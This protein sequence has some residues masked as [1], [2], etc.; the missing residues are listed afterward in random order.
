MSEHLCEQCGA[1]NAADA[2]F[3][4]K[5]D[6]YLGWDTGGGSLGG[7]PLKSSAPVV[8][9]THSQKFLAIPLAPERSPRPDAP[10]ATGRTSPTRSAMAPKVI[11]ESPEV[12]LD[13]AEGG[14]VD[15]RIH[16][17]SSIVDGYTVEAPNGPP[18]LTI[19]QPEIRLLT[20]QEEVFTV[21]LGMRPEYAVYVQRLRLRVQ[22]CS[23]EDPAK[24]TDAELV[25]VVPRVGGP[26]T[27]T[28]EP[29]LIRLRDATTGRFR[30]RLDNTGSN[31]PQR[32]AL[33]GS[34][35]EGVVRFS[36]RP[37]SVEVGPM[38]VQ[39]VDVRFD[40]PAPEPGQ[41]ANRTLTV[42]ATNNEG[43]VEAIVNVAHETSQAPPDSPVRLRLEPSVA[44]IRDMTSAEISVIVDN[45]RGSKDRRLLFSG[46]DPE[47]R[48]RF[49]FSQPQLYVRA[50][51]QARIGAHIEAPLPRPGEEVERPFAVVCN[52]GT[53]ESEA[54]GS[55]T[56]AASASP[57]TTAQI[58]LEPEH[59]VVRN[60]RRGRFRVTVD[61]SRGALPLSVWL[62]G[63]DPEGAVRFTFTPPRL[64]VP[65]G[66][67]GRAALRVWASL[68]G[69]GKEVVREIN[70][71]ANDGVGAVE[72]E[73][74]FTQSMSEIL[75]LLRLVF[76]LVG[77]LLVVLGAL[78][79]WFLGGPT[80][81][82]GRLLELQNLVDFKALGELENIQ[83]LEMI[84]QPAARALMLVFA[85]VMMLGILSA[86][87]RFTVIAGFLAAMLMVGYVAY[88]MSEFH[89]DGPAYG[90]LLVVLGAIIGIVGGF[91]IKRGGAT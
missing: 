59:V 10:Q 80:Y 38:R 1:T 87:G 63:T 70:V 4:A 43:R 19:T 16:N 78:R 85:G 7:S 23:V 84:T 12:V 45:R 62:S 71:K 82:I 21:T 48:V 89:S 55:L 86:S 49:A 56:Q 35:P 13:P 37:P 50:G 46:R 41:Q 75:P 24:R 91:C 66:N 73:G 34:D 27:I 76:T 29:H 64:D 42:T 31:Y 6:F 60:R 30:I 77:G 69:S 5:C 25:V 54:T 36:F 51:E 81:D 72:A 58:Q 20:D 74:R 79:P 39:V 9:E 2:Q 17:T 65:P 32:Y 90:A 57:I 26:V 15:I 28:P 44:R 8:R 14:T 3:C 18:W 11:L 83:K 53:D 47:G 61:N 67:I 68:P 88:A 40:A 33:T 22:I 52:D